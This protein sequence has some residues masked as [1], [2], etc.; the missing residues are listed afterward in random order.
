MKKHKTLSLKKVNIATINHALKIK[1]GATDTQICDP[2]SMNPTNCLNATFMRG[3][4]ITDPYSDCGNTKANANNCDS[5]S[6]VCDETT[7]SRGNGSI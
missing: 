6:L 2:K 1:G 4:V 7:T 3:C 5:Y